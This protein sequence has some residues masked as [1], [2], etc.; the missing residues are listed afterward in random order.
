MK[1]GKYVIVHVD[2]SAMARELV[3]D[4]LEDADFIVYNAEDAQDFEQRLMIDESVRNS[5]DLFIL[6]M[7]MPDLMGAQVG[8]IIDAVYED[9]SNVP[10]FI[11][12][13]KDRG[14]VENMSKEVAEM[15]EG[16]QRN[17]KGYLAKGPG[18]E[19]Q[20]VDKVKEILNIK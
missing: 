6:D 11:Y 15:S 9:L 5:V 12:S 13:G 10:F 4:A 20:V 18:S 17:H 7:E 16:F 14:W 3:K 19:D 8:A 1:D 2:D